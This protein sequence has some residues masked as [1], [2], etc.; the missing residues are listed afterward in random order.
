MLKMLNLLY[1]YLILYTVIKK[2]LY[3]KL[4]SIYLKIVRNFKFY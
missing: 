3:S 4:L 2:F 1:F